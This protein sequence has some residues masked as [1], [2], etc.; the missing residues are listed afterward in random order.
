MSYVGAADNIVLI[1]E[2][3]LACSPNLSEIIDCFVSNPINSA[4]VCQRFSIEGIVIVQSTILGE[5]S[6][7][8][9]TDL[10]AF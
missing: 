4:Q 8:V 9:P 7:F 6:R 2:S 1:F 5:D 3:V 10:C